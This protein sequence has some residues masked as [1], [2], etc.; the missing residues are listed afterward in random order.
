MSIVSAIHLHTKDAISINGKTTSFIVD[1]DHVLK[2]MGKTKG[3]C[4]VSCKLTSNQQQNIGSSNARTINASLQS[5]LSLPNSD[6]VVLATLEKKYLD[7]YTIYF[8]AQ[9]PTNQG[10]IIDIPT[11][12]QILNVVWAS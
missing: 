10:V 8:S 7:P 6:G 3:K 4:K 11:G 9:T 2:K 5:N 1:W 12:Q